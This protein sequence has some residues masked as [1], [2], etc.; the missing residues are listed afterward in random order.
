MIRRR[1]LTVPRCPAAAPQA[2]HPARGL[3][4]PPRGQNTYTAADTARWAS[5]DLRARA[6]DLPE[7]RAGHGHVTV[8]SRSGHGQVTVTGRPGHGQGE[9]GSV[10]RSGGRLLERKARHFMAIVMIRL[11]VVDAKLAFWGHE[12]KS[13]RTSACCVFLRSAISTVTLPYFKLREPGLPS[14]ILHFHVLYLSSFWC[15]QICFAQ[16]IWH[17]C[18]S[19]SDSELCICIDDFLVN[20]LPV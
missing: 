6:P 20:S 19:N 12:S 17:P 8:R 11:L 7:R 18:L 3:G 4:S 5:T 1:V 13:S 16:S 2:R 10:E 14:L 9:S 15:E